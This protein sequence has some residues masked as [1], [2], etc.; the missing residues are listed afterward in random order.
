MSV[1]VSPTKFYSKFKSVDLLPVQTG[2]LR[3]NLKSESHSHLYHYHVI[4]IFKMKTIFIKK[5]PD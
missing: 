4:S 5:S 3:L 2:F 1:N